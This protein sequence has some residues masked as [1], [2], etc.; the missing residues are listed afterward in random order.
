MMAKYQITQK[1][2]DL[3]VRIKKNAEAIV[4]ANQG[5][6]EETA[7]VLENCEVIEI[8]GS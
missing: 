2:Y 3:L 5:L 1:H 8:K 4:E 7:E 6:I